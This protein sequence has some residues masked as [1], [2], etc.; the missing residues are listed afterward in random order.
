MILCA[1]TRLGDPTLLSLPR[2][3]ID[4]S[5]TASAAGRV[6]QTDFTLEAAYPDERAARHY[7]QQLS[8]PWLACEKPSGWQRRQERGGTVHQQTHAWTDRVARRSI[9]VLLRYVTEGERAERP[10]YPIQHV[11][12]LEHIG[13]DV[14]DALRGLSLTCPSTSG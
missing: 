6:Y 8:R 10:A 4:A 9:V 2:D 7:A 14:D 3:A 13:V 12:V 1:C 5:H 11:I